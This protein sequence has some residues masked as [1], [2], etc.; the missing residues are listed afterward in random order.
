MKKKNYKV[1]ISRTPVQNQ[2]LDLLQ[3]IGGQMNIYTFYI[4]TEC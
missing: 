3:K 2:V 4:K 1:P